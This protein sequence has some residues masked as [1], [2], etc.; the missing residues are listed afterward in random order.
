MFKNKKAGIG[1]PEFF[2][3]SLIISLIFVLMA[4]N[5]QHSSV[6]RVIGNMQLP[7]FQADSEKN[8][9]FSVIDVNAEDAFDTTM[10][11]VDGRGG[12]EKDACGGWMQGCAILNSRDYPHDLCLPDVTKCLNK[13]FSQEIYKLN[14]ESGIHQLLFFIPFELYV[15]KSVIRGIPLKEIVFDLGVFENRLTGSEFSFRPAFTIKKDNELD[16][17][18]DV[19]F[20]VLRNIAAY[21][22]FQQNIT[23][24]YNDWL[25]EDDEK[26]SWTAWAENNKGYKDLVY[27]RI[28]FKDFDRSA[29]YGLYLPPA[30][31]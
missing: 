30:K 25:P 27:F 12:F 26:L 4:I 5:N 10:Q 29:C 18:P 21:C 16:Y 6:G 2:V 14:K 8:S 11:I 28:Y 17:Y 1:F 15:N 20:P 31:V 23:L 19:I 7:L 22:P 24:C 3:V 9:V 13:F